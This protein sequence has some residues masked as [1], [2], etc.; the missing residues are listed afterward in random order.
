MEAKSHEEIRSLVAAYVLGAVPEEE[1]PEIRAHLLT[2]EEC[3]ADADAYSS[4]TSD[5]AL[6]VEP[7]DLPAGFE[8]R[9]I[10]QIGADRVEVVRGTRRYAGWAFG[11]AC[12]LVA[13]GLGTAYLM[14]RGD[15]DRERRVASALLRSEAGMTLHGDGV[16]VM[17]P[18]RDGSVFVAEGLADPPDGHTYQLWLLEGDEPVSAG[19]FDVDDGRVVIE[20]DRSVEGFD[21]AAVTV[22]PDGGSPEPTTD[23]VVRTT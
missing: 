5:L 23:P 20:L 1:Q 13:I 6:A 15:L 16:A 18:T 8:D 11:V 14:A 22:E 2:C 19:T 7:E 21:G 3:M 4:V 9:V 10:A 17:V 12:L